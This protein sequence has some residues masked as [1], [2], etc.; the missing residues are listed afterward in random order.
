ML[1]RSSAVRLLP[2]IAGLLLLAAAA[3]AEGPVFDHA[4]HN[5]GTDTEC[6]ACHVEGAASI[7]PEGSVCSACHE[8]GFVDKVV[9]PALSTHG[10]LWSMNHRPFA[11]GGSADCASCHQQ[12]D[13]LECHI[14][15]DADEMGSFGNQMANIHRSDFQVSHPIAARTNPQLCTS[16]H[17]VSSCTSCH[18]RFAPA[19][20]AIKSHRRGFTDGTLNGQHALYNETQCATCHPD[21]VLPAHEWSSNHAREA[22]KNLASCQACHPQGDTCLK[23]HSARTGLRAN[24]HP[25][26]WGSIKDNLEDASNGRTCRRCH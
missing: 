22:R 24:P 16:C 10:P 13:C 26:D 4:T 23:C 5:A 19:D 18:D 11:K 9:F 14:A 12:S 15:G 21:S 7:F 17:E 1:N 6:A 3:S 20:L 25:A 2:L 8:A